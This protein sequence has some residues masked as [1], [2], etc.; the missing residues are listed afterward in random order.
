MVD[1]IVEHKTQFLLLKNINLCNFFCG[2]TI[3]N[4]EE[5][6]SH[7]G[8]TSLTSR[9]KAS[10]HSRCQRKIEGES[11]KGLANRWNRKR[12]TKKAHAGRGLETIWEMS[13]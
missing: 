6:S 11:K 3:G 7:P 5:V 8:E 4:T 13:A 1:E 10:K 12:I 2:G 9:K